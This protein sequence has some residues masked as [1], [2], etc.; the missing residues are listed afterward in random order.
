MLGVEVIHP[1]SFAAT[2]Q[3]GNLRID[4]SHL[5]AGLYFVKVGNC[6]EKFVKI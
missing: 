1:V 2:P 6:I 3:D 5:P 4:V